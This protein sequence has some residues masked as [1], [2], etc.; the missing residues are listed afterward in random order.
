MTLSRPEKYA[1]IDRVIVMF[2][3]SGKE[4]EDDDSECK[5][6]VAGG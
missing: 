4:E 1:L 2:M 3:S 5:Y 6:D